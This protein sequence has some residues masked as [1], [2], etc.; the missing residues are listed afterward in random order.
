MDAL[1]RFLAVAALIVALASFAWQ[2]YTWRRATGRV[3]VSLRGEVRDTH[4]DKSVIAVVT[5][6]NVGRGPA[7][8]ESIGFYL[9]GTYEP[10]VWGKEDDS[11][12][13]PHELAPGAAQVWR[14]RLVHHGDSHAIS[15]ALDALAH[16]GD[17]RMVSSDP[18]RFEVPRH[19]E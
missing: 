15:V 7:F 1:A 6:R 14:Y 19:A 9:L 18:C 3:K 8:I 12:D 10:V 11:P 13:F 16:L 17:G 5:V 4:D 2:V